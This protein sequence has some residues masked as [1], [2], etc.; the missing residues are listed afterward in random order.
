MANFRKFKNTYKTGD[1]PIATVELN[2]F[3]PTAIIKEIEYDNLI[4]ENSSKYI[5]S[6]TLTPLTNGT[7]SGLFP[8]THYLPTKHNSIDYL[9]S[10]KKNEE[11]T[12]LYYVY[13]LKF[14]VYGMSNIDMVQIYKNNVD[15]VPQ[16]KYKIEFGT[17]TLFENLIGDNDSNLSRYGSSVVWGEFN[18]VKTVHRVRLLLPIDMHDKDVFHTVRYNKHYLNIQ[19]PTHLELLEL[20]PLYSKTDF[21]W[22]YDATSNTELIKINKNELLNVK[23]LYCSKDPNKRIFSDDIATVSSDGLVSESKSSWNAKVNVGSFVRSNSSFHTDTSLYNIQYSAESKFQYQVVSYVKPKDVGYNIVKVKE[24]QIYISGYVYPNYDIGLFPNITDSNTLPEGSIGINIDNDLVSDL[25]IASIDRHKGYIMF[26]K[27]ISSNNEVAMFLYN[28]LNYNLI[29]SNLEL[30]PRIKS[31]YGFNNNS[32]IKSFKDI[33]IAI[34]KTDDHTVSNDSLYYHPYFFD[35]ADPTNFYLSQVIS[36]TNDTTVVSGSLCW[37]PYTSS[38]NTSG[39]FIPITVISLNKLGLDVIDI[40]D[41]RRINGGLADTYIPELNNNQDNSYADIG[42]FDGSLL[43]HEGLKIIHLPASIYT[44]LITRWKTSGLFNK[45]MYT[46]VTQYEVENFTTAAESGY[47]DL[48]LEGKASNTEDQ[49]QSAYS[50]MLEE[51]AEHEASYYL[52]KVIKKYIPAGTSYLLLDEN[53]KEIK[54]RLDK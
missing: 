35:F 44:N 52:D 28:D 50:K 7:N 30:N 46:D 29:I 45:E 15:I 48:L 39:E 23:T 51:W 3:N 32:T 41:A 14:D 21:T 31:K 1:C 6:E 8:V 26:N 25:K 16:S 49:V 40:K 22:S 19:T 17:T 5:T 13:E 54:L 36:T 2:N 47:Y 10:D 20:E 42:Y 33:G 12:A 27:S 38:S 24:H 4:I 37:N 43:P 11:N 9:M 53:F 34:R 18:S